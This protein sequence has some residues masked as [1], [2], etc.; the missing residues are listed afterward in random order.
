MLKTP[1]INANPA[2]AG[3]SAKTNQVYAIMPG[4]AST[5]AP[6]VATNGA[7]DPAIGRQITIPAGVPGLPCWDLYSVAVELLAVAG[8]LPRRNRR[9]G[10]AQHCSQRDAERQLY[11][12]G[13]HGRRQYRHQGL[14]PTQI[15]LSAGQ[16][17]RSYSQYNETSYADFARSQ[18]ALFGNVRPRLPVDGGILQFSLGASDGVTRSLSFAGTANFDPSNGGIAGSLLITSS[19]LNGI[20]DITAPGATPII[21][22]STVSSSDLNAF[23]AAALFVGGADLFT[24][25]GGSVGG[26]SVWYP[27]ERP[28]R[29]M[30]WMV[31]SCARGRSSSSVNRSALQAGPPS[32]RAA[33]ATPGSIPVSAMCS[34][35]V[36]FLRSPMA[37]STSCRRPEPGSMTIASGASLLTEG[38]IVLGAPG[39]LSMGDVNFGARFLTVTQDTINAGDAAALAAAQA[40]GVLPTGW[41]LTQASL[42]RLLRPSSTAGVPALERLTLTAGGSINLFGSVTLDA[43]SQSGS[44]VEFVLNTPAIYGLGTSADTA[45][46][47]A[48]HLIWNGIRTGSVDS[49]TGIPHYAS[50]A[51]AAIRP[52]GAGTGAGNLVLQ[53]QDITLGYDED[54]RPTDG[55]TLNRVA[56]GFANVAIN[57]GNRITANSDGTLSVGQSKD[58]SGKLIGGN[59]TLTTPLVTAEAGS[60]IDYKAGGAIRVTAPAGV[61]PT[62]T[63]VVADLGGTLSFNGD[64]VFVDTAFALPS[65]KLTLTAVNDVIIGSN[66]RVDLAGRTVAFYDVN[67]YGWGGDLVMQSVHGGI[68]QNAGSLIDV[69]AA[70]NQAGSIAAIADDGQIALN[71]TLRGSSLV[72]D[73]QSG[74]IG[75]RA[76]SLGDFA[77]LNTM[78]NETGFFGSRAIRA[79]ARR[80]RRRQRCARA[81]GVD[82]GG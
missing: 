38:S 44:D 62:D 49:T 14:L 39:S 26:A 5:Y 18:A 75:L 45:T 31:L 73:S 67:K 80:S 57:A 55:V 53:A 56:V 40:G 17:T 59:L 46:I 20:I 10:H 65:G 74:R 15:I 27:S 8:R 36:T 70:Y 78:L 58:S 19:A 4:Y 54:S 48:D 3:F 42:D 11:R 66:A 12:V 76:Q 33:K 64:S 1:L 30:F 2:Y 35:A 43:R 61:A 9:T 21:G 63:S 69:S 22:H 32:T 47:V 50:Q 81:Y 24:P 6:L 77:A 16:A 68:T 29:S 37:G 72:S 13:H 34:T 23:H 52:N 28:R 60:T 82:R 71:G 41:A 25:A 51:P 79:Q 7:G